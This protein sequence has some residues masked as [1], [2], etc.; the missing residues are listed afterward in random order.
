MEWMNEFTAVKG[1]LIRNLRIRKPRELWTF[2]GKFK[3]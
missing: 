1:I 2:K 3:G